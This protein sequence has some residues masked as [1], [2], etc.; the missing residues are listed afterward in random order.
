MSEWAHVFCQ[1][2]MGAF[3]SI[4]KEDD[5]QDSSKPPEDEMSSKITMAIRQ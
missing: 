3:T 2:E 5:P 4:I 1:S